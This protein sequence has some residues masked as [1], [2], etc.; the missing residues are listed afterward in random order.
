MSHGHHLVL[1]AC[2]DGRSDQTKVRLSISLSDDRT[3]GSTDRDLPSP[4][5]GR[6]ASKA[7]QCGMGNKAKP[8]TDA[9]WQVVELDRRTTRSLH[10]QL[11][12][13]TR[14]ECLRNPSWRALLASKKGI[15]PA[16]AS[17]PTDL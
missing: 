5:N 14:C 16:S 1:N 13:H 17:K 9:C 6:L 12:R 11:D 7:D 3:C 2:L 10:L 15:L 8:Y 4:E